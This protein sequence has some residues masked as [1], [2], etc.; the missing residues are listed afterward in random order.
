MPEPT[1]RDDRWY[2]PTYDTVE[3]ERQHRKQRLAAGFE[4]ALKK[5]A[6]LAPEKPEPRFQLAEVQAVTGRITIDAERNASK[7]AVIIQV[8]NG[9]FAFVE[10]MAP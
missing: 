7:S 10:S 6:S 1:T 9:K 5:M 2:L 8:K 3:E 4:A